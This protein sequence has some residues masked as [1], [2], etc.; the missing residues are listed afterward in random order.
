M[1]TLQKELLKV[2]RR[3]N[4][5]IKDDPQFSPYY[6]GRRYIVFLDYGHPGALGSKDFV[7]KTE[8]EAWLKEYVKHKT[9]G[10]TV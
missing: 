9:G 2:L 5:G 6:S 1:F 4:K 8:A 7:T 3:E 10:A